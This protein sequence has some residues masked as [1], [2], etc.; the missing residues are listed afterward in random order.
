[1]SNTP[2]TPADAREAKYTACDAYRAQIAGTVPAHRLDTRQNGFL[3]G[4]DAALA[5]AAEQASK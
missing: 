1:M 3:D 4:W 2:N 5:W